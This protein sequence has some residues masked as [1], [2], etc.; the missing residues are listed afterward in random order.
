MHARAFRT[1]MRRGAEAPPPALAH[2]NG[3]RMI[4]R[5]WRQPRSFEKH[6]AIEHARARAHAR[7][8]ITD[9]LP[10]GSPSRRCTDARGRSCTPAR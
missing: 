1:R 3:R 8:A 10:P 4:I 2:C 9:P 7:A 6:R 5:T